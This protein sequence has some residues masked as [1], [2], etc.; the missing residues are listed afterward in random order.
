MVPLGLWDTQSANRCVDTYRLCD[1]YLG[2]RDNFAA[3]RELAAQLEQMYP[4]LRGILHMNR[5][6]LIRAVTWAARQ[7]IAQFLDLGAGLPD[8]PA[9]A[10]DGPPRDPQG[11]LRL[12]RQ[13][14]GGR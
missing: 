14:P 8:V 4:P 7:R 3:D 12:R 10:P 6:F 11:A 13:R 2:G 9:A 5:A 1:Y